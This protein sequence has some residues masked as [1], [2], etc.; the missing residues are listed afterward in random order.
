MFS[1]GLL[2]ASIVVCGSIVNTQGKHRGLKVKTKDAIEYFG[3][4]KKLA[5]A[6]EIW[7]HVI[8]RW[9]EFPPMARQY[10]IE[11]KTG[12]KLKAGDDK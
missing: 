10:E 5:E 7:P 1:C 4:T 2:V 12:G 11:V 9:G 6:L 8:Y 3:G